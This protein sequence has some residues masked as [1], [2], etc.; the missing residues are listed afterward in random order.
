M[1]FD[2]R[3]LQW[4]RQPEDYRITQDRIFSFTVKTDF[5][6]SGHRFDQCGVVLYLDSENWI[7][8]SIEYEN[9]CFQHLGSVVIWN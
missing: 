4:T 8:G 6:E 5:A 1:K 2:V 3:N 9:G 7:K